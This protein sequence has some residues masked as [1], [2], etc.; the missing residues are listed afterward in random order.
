MTACL[1]RLRATLL[2]TVFQRSHSDFESMKCFHIVS[3][4]TRSQMLYILLALRQVPFIDIDQ[5]ED[6]MVSPIM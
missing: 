3:S 6:I 1:G 5:L 2:L 4:Q